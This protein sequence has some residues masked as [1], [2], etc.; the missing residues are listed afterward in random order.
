MGFR[1]RKDLKDECKERGVKLSFMP[2]FLKAAS[3]ALAKYPILN[4]SLDTEQINI[5]YKVSKLETKNHVMTVNH[6]FTLC[7]KTSPT[8]L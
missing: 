3:M 5:I 2:F 8:F 7:S 6:I 1:L 4:A